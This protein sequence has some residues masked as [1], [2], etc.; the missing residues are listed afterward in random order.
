M[1]RRVLVSIDREMTHFSA[2]ASHFCR[3]RPIGEQTE[4]SRPTQRG[5]CLH[6][7]FILFGRFLWV[8][9]SFSSAYC[10]EGDTSR[11]GAKGRVRGVLR[12][13]CL[14]VTAHLGWGRNL[15]PLPLH[16]WCPTK[17]LETWLHPRPVSSG[18]LLST[19]SD[20]LFCFVP[21]LRYSR[22]ALS[23]TCS[24]RCP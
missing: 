13:L 17:I 14:V 8:F 21:G 12:A 7:I 1:R 10:P 16:P 24:G 22:L 6:C 15:P 3:V 9:P 23:S 4:T 2:A 19:C 20:G 11:R 18:S 5:F